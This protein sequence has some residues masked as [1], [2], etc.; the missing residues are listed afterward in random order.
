MFEHL[1]D[2]QYIFVSGMQRSGTTPC[3]RMIQWELEIPQ[4]VWLG[5]VPD[6]AK[7]TTEKE[8]FK[9]TR[10][11]FHSPAISHL[12]HEIPA[13]YSEKVAIVWV[14]RDMDEIF[15]SA[16]RVGWDPTHELKAYNLEFNRK[17][18]VKKEL[19]V[20]LRDA[21]EALWE[22]QKK[23]IPYWFEVDYDDLKKH[24]MWLQPE[25]RIEF[26]S[27]QVGLNNPIVSGTGVRHQLDPDTFGDLESLRK[28]LE[29]KKE[30]PGDWTPPWVK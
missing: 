6:R 8:E 3:M 25:E 11:V 14:R 19:M 2:F 21:K 13:A 1:K 5:P 26:H 17:E 23:D 7:E 22:K 30:E 15:R 29:V 10:I 12:L 9:N 28:E 24:P 20:S 27:R 16:M 18:G 4:A